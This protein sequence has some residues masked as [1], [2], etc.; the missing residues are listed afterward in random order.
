M[1]NKMK[2][3]LFLSVA[4]LPSALSA[5]E[6][7]LLD[8]I[9]LEA[10]S[11][12]TLVQDG[13]IARSGRQA[14]RVDTPI[15]RLPQ[16]VSVVTQDQLEDQR[17][18]TMLEALNYTAAATPGN[19][20][21]DS[22]Y[23][24][25]YLRGFPAYQTG[26]F[27]D[28][29]RSVNGL[30]AWYRNDPYTL[31]G[32]AVLK[33]PAS[34]MFGV[35][36]PGGVVNMVSKRPKDEPYRETRLSFGSYDR[37]EAAL[38]FTGPLDADGDV[39]YRFVALARDSDTHIPGYADDRIL[40]A[41]SLSF[42]L[43][44][45]QKLLVTAEYAKDKTG[46][47]A[48]YHFGDDLKVTDAPAG[49]PDY[50]N[51]DQ[52]QFR[53]GY[54]YSWDIGPD[55]QLRQSYRYSEVEVDMR[56]ATRFGT[57][58]DLVPGWW[59]RYE[60]TAK[61]HVLDLALEH[62]FKTGSFDHTLVFG[63]DYTRSKYT[64]D[65]GGTGAGRAVNEAMDVPFLSWRDQT[66]KGIY[67]ADV[68]E[69]NG[70]TI[71]ASARYDQVETDY[72]D[73]NSETSLITSGT[74]K[75]EA[76]TA[77]LGAS[78]AMASGMTPFANVSSSFAPNIGQVYDDAADPLGNPAAA[79][80]ALQ[81]EIGL[82]YEMPDGNTVITASL[83]DIRQDNGMV[84]IVGNDGR[85]RGLQYDLTSRGVELEAASN[86]GNGLSVIASYAHM[87]VKINEGTPGTE[88]K[89]LSGV[90]QD[91]LSLFAKYDVQ[92]G[93]LE[94]LS[95]MGGIRYIGKSYGDDMNTIENA[96]RTYVDLGVAYDFAAFGHTG[97]ELQV[98]VRNLFD[99]EGQTCTGNWCYA[100]EPRMVD[101]SLAH[102]F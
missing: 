88:N 49:D 67:I 64:A 58:P 1:K 84:L 13:Y 17:P 76:F 83:F 3:V 79:T 97:T 14:M 68:I 33:G 72:A 37:K 8:P 23:D 19:F 48:Y 30:S 51:F 59:E 94:N 22:R 10:E 60:E 100:D 4:I 53:V 41:P 18:R 85:N 93:P 82:K 92:S 43:S 50:N 54:E 40:I 34:S 24:S 44:D 81:K 31:E 27:R 63:A 39:L 55:T 98:N 96:S 6:A 26:M 75:D 69:R 74:Q 80:E 11:D 52:E 29:L 36:T 89:E 86:L 87:K 28:G 62:R 78:Y 38:D 99:R 7:I 73:L 91:T 47:V 45:T 9:T 71:A 25:F 16:S 95:V 66:Q 102:R 57:Y 77:R 90:P 5:Q 56:Y 42:R 32:I 101:V 12:E 70:L 20:G 61:T 21:F 2:S 46:A 65:Y 15:S 35:S